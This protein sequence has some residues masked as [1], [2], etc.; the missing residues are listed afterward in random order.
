MSH[1]LISAAELASWLRG[2]SPQDDVLVLD[3]RFSLANP[4][5]GQQAY[6]Q[7]HIP[8]A[9]YVHLERDL[10]GPKTGLNGRHPLP[11]PEAF[12]RTFQGWA[13]PAHTEVHC[14]D[15]R[16]AALAHDTDLVTS[17]DPVAPREGRGYGLQ[18]RH[19][20]VTV[21]DRD[22]I[23]IDHAAAELHDA[24]RGRT[25]GP[26]AEESQIDATVPRP[27]AMGRCD[28]GSQNAEPRHRPD[29]VIRHLR[30]VRRSQRVCT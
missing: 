15:G 21:V 29:P 28:V 10:S 1:T 18:R 9:V 23:P 19:E 17:R 22:Q 12:N 13:L 30:G 27:V 24:R 5:A 8:G 3:C 26:D 16:V 2:A 25:D 14:S 11:T 20:P 7:G 4:Q 6:E